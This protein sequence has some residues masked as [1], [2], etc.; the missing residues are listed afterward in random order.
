MKWRFLAIAIFFTMLIPIIPAHADDFQSVTSHYNQYSP[1]NFSSSYNRNES[2]YSAA[3]VS[4]HYSQTEVQ[5]SAKNV[6]DPFLQVPHDYKAHL[7]SPE[8]SVKVKKAAKKS[9]QDQAAAKF[10]EGKTRKVPVFFLLLLISSF[11][12]AATIFVII[13][14][15]KK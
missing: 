5:F 7:V 4:N 13:G 2:R 3:D 10:L 12:L 15:F 8:S 14:I 11:A 1:D 9:A 6:I